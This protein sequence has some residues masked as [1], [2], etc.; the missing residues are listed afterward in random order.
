MISFCVYFLIIISTTTFSKEKSNY[1]I[2][3][4]DENSSYIFDTVG[5]DMEI[6]PIFENSGD[7]SVFNRDCNGFKMGCGN[8]VHKIQ[9]GTCYFT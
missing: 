1:L 4:K 3:T 9:E 5:E 7:Y 6:I 8:P 2:E